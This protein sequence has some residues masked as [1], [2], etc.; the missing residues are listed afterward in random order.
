[1]RPGM[2]LWK[3]AVVA[4]GLAAL[5]GSA[6]GDDGFYVIPVKNRN[7]ITTG[8]NTAIGKGAFNATSTGSENTASGWE[9]LHT[10]TSG[11]SNTA[12]G[13]RALYSNTT[14][15]YNTASGAFALIANTTGD[16]NTASGWNALL[17]N[18]TGTY[19]T[20]S[21]MAALESNTT[22][23]YNTASGYC[24][25]SRN[26]TGDANTASG[27]FALTFNTTGNHNTASGSNA[28]YANH[29]GNM[30]TA[31]GN[32]ALCSNQTGNYN[33]AVG[34]YALRNSH[35][36]GNTALGI[37]A[38]YNLNPGDVFTGNQNIYLGQDVSPGSLTESNTIRIGNSYQSQTFIAGIASAYVSSAVPVYVKTDGQLGTVTSSRRYKED[39]RD[40][41]DASR[42]LMQLRPVT[43][44]Y[45]PEYASGKRTRQYGLIAEEVAEVY[46]E[47]VLSDPKT[48]QPQTVAYHLVNAMLL[49]EVQKQHRLVREQEKKIQALEEQTKEL[50]GLKEQVRELSAL[51]EQVRA[52]SALVAQNQEASRRLSKLAD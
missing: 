32:E 37:N 4:L 25:L 2:R 6:W 18:T 24:A 48:G 27:A 49:N 34:S 8:T 1:M 3:L 9:A 7:I 21:G 45:K 10:N 47:L 41:G 38:G 42:G 36:Y 31:M 35:G 13:A 11:Y 23:Y 14:G 29:T 33:T 19:N 20:A 17:S 44:H 12:C 50:S 43:F 5:C 30:N 40:M 26:E 51:K 16:S 39:I 15:N 22:G 52:L 28:L 46:P